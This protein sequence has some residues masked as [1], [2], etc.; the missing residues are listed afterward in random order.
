MMRIIEII[1]LHNGSHNNQAINGADPATFHVP[2]GWAIIPDGMETPNFPFGS[3][4]VD[5]QTPPVVTSWTPLPIPEPETPT[6]AKLREEAYN[7][8]AIISWDGE[9][10]T[11]TEAS[12]KWQYYAA[13]GDTVK[14]DELT[15]LIAEA[16]AKIREQYSD[17]NKEASA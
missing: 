13:E 5:N 8:Q 15:E 4:T 14:T 11:V 7:T 12:Q 3:I 1:E 9:M 10:L 6:P 2:D 17:E 16:K